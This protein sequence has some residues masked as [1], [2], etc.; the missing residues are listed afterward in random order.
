MTRLVLVPVAG[1]AL[2][3]VLALAFPPYDLAWIGL[4]ALPLL[5]AIAFCLRPLWGAVLGM[6][7]GLAFFG[8]YLR[9]LGVL[10]G[11]A[12]AGAVVIQ[13]LF[14]CGF[15]CLLPKITR[16]LSIPSAL[17]AGGLWAIFEGLRGAIPFGGF[18]WG[19]LGSSLHTLTGPRR[20]ASAIGTSGLS[21]LLIIAAY[22]VVWLIVGGGAGGGASSGRRVPAFGPLLLV[23]LAMFTPSVQAESGRTVTLA[24]VQ[25]GIESPVFV[26]ADSQEI[27]DRHIALT[28][29]LKGRAVDVVLWGEGVIDSVSAGDVLP[30]LSAEI[31]APIAAGA[32]EPGRSGGFLNLVVATDGERFL[33]RYAKQHPVPFGEYVPLR[34][35]LGRVPVLAREIPFDMERGT[36]PALFDYGPVVAA[37]V[38]SFESTFP[39]LSRH[40][41]KQGAEL[42]Q[43]HTNNS[44]YGR[45][46]ASSQH[47][48][49]DQMRAAE[50]GVPVA[51]SAITGISAVID[52]HGKVR[53][54]MEIFETGILVSKV[55]LPVG[56][57]P[58]RRFGDLLFTLPL[59]IWSIAYLVVRQ[60]RLTGGAPRHRPTTP[61]I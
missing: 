20:L 43:V 58:Y 53:G 2:G 60:M 61:I 39:T 27:L 59:E 1:P 30:A 36:K 14:L 40:A 57:T 12:L 33:G 31:G 18:P 32:I 38:I 45:G 52:A 6:G 5:L 24:L 51:R 3:A 46:P 47:L 23:A 11:V 17:A 35:L 28:R 4:L 25:A 44:T 7:A 21:A 19:T 22:L 48:S 26:P 42:L 41:V 37:P 55:Q 56:S 50:L 54:R 29:T 15:F 16:R 34:S 9:W 8:I 10:G 49:L 13:A